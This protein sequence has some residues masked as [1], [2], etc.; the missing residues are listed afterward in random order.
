MPVAELHAK[1]ALDDQEQLVLA[2]VV[3]P[4][5]RPPEPD[6]LDLLAVQLADDPGRPRLGEAGELLGEVDLA[7]AFR[8][9]LPGDLPQRLGDGV[10]SSRSS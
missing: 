9:L 1:A 4:D 2:F 5:E 7:H 8:S 6:E 3:V 10:A